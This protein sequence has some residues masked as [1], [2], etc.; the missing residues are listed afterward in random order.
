MELDLDEPIEMLDGNAAME[1]AQKWREAMDKELQKMVG[2]KQQYA[3]TQ[4]ELKQVIDKY[5]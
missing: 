5:T 2:L 3:N 1:L 4:P